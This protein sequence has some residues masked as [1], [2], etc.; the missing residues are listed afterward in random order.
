VERRD[1]GDGRGA[2]ILK[3]HCNSI[4]FTFYINSLNSHRISVI[5]HPNSV[6][7]HFIL[8][9]SHRIPVI[10]HLFSHVI[11]VNSL[12]ILLNSVISPLNSLNAFLACNSIRGEY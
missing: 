9:N 10:S 12:L 1:V 11:S 6:N 3:N 4:H 7:A 8:L 5:S 2:N